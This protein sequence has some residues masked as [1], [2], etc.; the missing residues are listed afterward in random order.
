MAGKLEEIAGLCEISVTVLINPHRD[1]YQTVE[2][3]L[4]NIDPDVVS[5]DIRSNMVLTDT[6]VSVYC[7]PDTPI[8]FYVV[9]HYDIS[10]ALDEM[11]EILRGR[12]E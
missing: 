2:E 6:V 12:N 1:N 4:G 3:F 9:H 5:D 10:K 11:L 7:Y 8:G